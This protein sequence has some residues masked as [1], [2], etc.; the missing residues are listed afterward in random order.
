[1]KVAQI[2]LLLALAFDIVTRAYNAVDEQKLFLHSRSVLVLE[3]NDWTANDPKLCELDGDV[4]M[5]VLTCRDHDSLPRKATVQFHGP[6]PSHE[7]KTS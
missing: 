3:P 1:M 4:D 7:M 6:L 5:P 2:V